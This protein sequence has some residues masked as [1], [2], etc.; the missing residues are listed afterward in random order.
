MKSSEIKNP[1]STVHYF[2]KN[3]FCDRKSETKKIIDYLENGNS[4]SLIALRRIGK[5]G[6]IKHISETLPSS[7][8]LIYIDILE[9]ESMEQFLDCIA[10]ELLKQ[11]PEKTHIGKQIWN[12]IKSLRPTI[13]FDPLTGSPQASFTNVQQSAEKNVEVLLDFLEQQPKRIVIAID[14][15]QQIIEY[16]QKNIDAWLRKKMQQ[17]KNVLFIFSGSQQ[18]LMTELFLQSDKPFYRSTQIIRLQKIDETNYANFIIRLFKRYNKTISKDIAKQILQWCD[19]HTFYVQQ[20]CNRVFAL[21]KPI[22]EEN[23][24]KQEASNLLKENEIL[25]YT[26]R[27][28]LTKHQWKLLK[29]IAAEGKTYRPTAQDFINKYSLGS[30][31]TILKSLASLLKIGIVFKDFDLEGQQYYG[32]YDIYLRRW[33]ETKKLGH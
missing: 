25:F 1:F 21:N 5:T 4:I 8:K 33:C 15:F 28:T 10:T 11:L 20:L 27:E 29:A 24:W 30:S 31:A 22:T 18:H 23:D 2:G 14:E 19:T 3:Y 6:L 7:F 32:V 9:T 12:F 26:Y 16:P 17:L 13:N